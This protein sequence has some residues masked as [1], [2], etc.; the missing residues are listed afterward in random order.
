[1]AVKH[2]GNR[3]GCNLFKEQHVFQ[4]FSYLYERQVDDMLTNAFETTALGTFREATL[5]EATAHTKLILFQHTA[6]AGRVYSPPI[7]KTLPPNNTAL[8]AC[9]PYVHTCYI[10]IN[11]IRYSSQLVRF[12]HLR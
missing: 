6:A 10:P 2:W 7:T 9:V 3:I 1:M 11:I 8:L 4:T 12:T 5:L